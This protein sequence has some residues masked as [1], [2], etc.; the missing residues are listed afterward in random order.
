MVLICIYLIA[1]MLNIFSCA[2][3]PSAHVLF[4]EH[5]VHIFCSFSNWIVYFILLSFNSSLH[6]LDT[7][8]LL[9]IWLKRILSKSVACLFILLTEGESF[10]LCIYF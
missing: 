6:I 9:G 5:F 10:Y 7:S 1:V 2:F 4:G 8:S 3:L